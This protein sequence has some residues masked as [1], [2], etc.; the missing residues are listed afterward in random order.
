M[1]EPE[2][3]TGGELNAGITSSLVGIHHKYLGRGPVTA[4][5]FHYGTSW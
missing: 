2:R 5:T 3:L 4:T 1:G